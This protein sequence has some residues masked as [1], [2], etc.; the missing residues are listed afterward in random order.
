MDF[1]IFI[2]AMLIGGV[3]AWQAFSWYYAKKFKTPKQD[4]ATESHVLLER[5][6]NDDPTALVGLPLIALSA[7]LRQAG[8]RLP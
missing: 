6:E 3:A 7:A 8:Y 2:L 5:I 1:L 4:V